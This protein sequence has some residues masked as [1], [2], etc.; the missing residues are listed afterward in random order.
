MSGCGEEDYIIAMSGGHSI[1][2]RCVLDR[3]H[4]GRHIMQEHHL[5]R[6]D[7]CMRKVIK[8]EPLEIGN[9]C[10][11]ENGHEGPC[12]L[13]RRGACR[14]VPLSEFKRIRA[15]REAEGDI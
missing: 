14:S 7:L 1:N 2:I 13:A 15:L 10:K 6:L 5:L 9:W 12:Y 8:D 11:R 3:G 4:D